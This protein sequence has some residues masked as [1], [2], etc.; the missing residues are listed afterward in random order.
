MKTVDQVKTIINQNKKW[1]STEGK[2][3]KKPLRNKA[4]KEIKLYSELLMYLE[5]QPR[6]DFVIS[7]IKRLKR[8]IESKNSQFSNWNEKVCPEDVPV[9]KRRALFNKENEIPKYRAQLKNLEI[10]IN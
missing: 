8:I 9:K 7:E 5:T 6:E 3:A 2:E 10:L 4:L 1:L